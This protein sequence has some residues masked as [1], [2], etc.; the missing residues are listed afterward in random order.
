MYGRRQN[1]TQPKV[2][3]KESKRRTT[4]NTKDISFNAAIVYLLLKCI[5]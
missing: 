5:L 3:M 2:E 1:F 4:L